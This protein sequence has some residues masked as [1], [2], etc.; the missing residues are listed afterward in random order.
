MT[1]RLAFSL[2]MASLW[3]RRKVLALVTLTLTLSITLL[4]GVQYLRTEVK[5]T[6]TNTI[7][8][9][10]LIVGA[11]S[12]Q[13]NLLM[14]TI[15]HIGDATNNIRWNTYQKLQEDQRIDWLVPLSL[16]D[17]YRGHRV[18]GTSEQF[19][20]YFRYG[21]DQKP[22]LVE[23]KWFSEVFEVV[24]GARV[25]RRHGHQ[26]GDDIILSHGGGRTSFSN[27]KD[28]PFTV[29]GVLAP[30]GTPVDQAVY[31]SLEG[32]EA[33]H[34]G[35]ESG[36]AIPG[37]T[38]TPEQALERDLA[39]DNITAA[40]VGIER[41]VLTFQ[42]QREINEFREEPLSAILPGVALS[43]LWR[44]MG[45]FENA[46]LGITGFVVV[47]SLIGLIAVL[48]TLQ[49]QRRQEVA[50]LRATGASPLLIAA[51]HVIECVA[52]AIAACIL[53]VIAGA[54]GIAGLS[55]WLLET[56]GI[57]IGLRPLNGMEWLIIAS[58]PCAA[59]VVGLIPA[60]QA[61]R[62][63]RKQGLGHVAPE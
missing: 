19:P 18:V 16:G 44:I 3:Y 47:T 39:P 56:W 25:A 42:V 46:L 11:R 63:S 17:S 57:Q 24:L 5:Q 4:L 10:D 36:V 12:G 62:G 15:F 31:V 26:L 21:R 49:V 37:R 8:G 48:L 32:L 7:S 13:L 20:E 35:W 58:V 33:I 61:W 34:I 41:K 1:V 2:A 53:A 14:Y 51:L 45:Q 40:L 50:I 30:T 59:F 28:T 55:P 27:H 29:A 43:E 60:L 52:L 22:E 38:V 9:T 23:G 6:F 54:A